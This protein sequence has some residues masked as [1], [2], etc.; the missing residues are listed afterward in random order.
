MAATREQRETHEVEVVFGAADV[1]AELA[2]V[3]PDYPVEQFLQVEIL[4]DGQAVPPDARVT[5]RG[6]L[7]HSPHG[8][9]QRRAARGTPV[10]P[11]LITDEAEAAPRPGT[12][13]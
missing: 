2:R 13:E 3:W 9:V 12:V 10:M 4:I 5:L 7:D 1:T 6:V 11:T 8:I